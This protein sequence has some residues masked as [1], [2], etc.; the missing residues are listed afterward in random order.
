MCMWLVFFFF[1]FFLLSQSVWF[2][3]HIFGWNKQYYIFSNQWN[4]QFYKN[5][6]NSTIIIF[7]SLP[8]RFFPQLFFTLLHK[9]NIW[10]CEIDILVGNCQFLKRHSLVRKKI[11][12]HKDLEDWN[13]IFSLV[14][15]NFICDDFPVSYASFNEELRWT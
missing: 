6:F 5:L 13:V 7:F 9:I 1:I 10:I 8:R 11:S 15:E 3:I 14:F 12:P 4:F 2:C